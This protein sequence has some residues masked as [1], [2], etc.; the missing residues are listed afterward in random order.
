MIDEYDLIEDI[1]ISVEATMLVKVSV[2]FFPEN[3]IR[4]KY[5]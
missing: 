2:V 1:I 4:L 3:S 5:L